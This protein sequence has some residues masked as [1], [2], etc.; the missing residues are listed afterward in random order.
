V[1]GKGCFSSQ[2]NCDTTMGCLGDCDYGYCKIF[3]KKGNV[4]V[5]ICNTKSLDKQ[6]KKINTNQSVNLRI[7][8]FTDPG[9]E[10][11]ELLKLLNWCKVNNIKPILIT[12]MPGNEDVVKEITTC[13][14][15]MHISLGYD[16]LEKS[17]CLHN[18]TND[19]RFM[20]GLS[21]IEKGYNVIFRLVRE[22]TGQADVFTKELISK[23]KKYI[24]LTP[25][26]LKSKPMIQ[27]LGGDISKY[28]FTGGF[29]RPDTL[30]PDYHNLNSCYENKEGI[31]CSKCL[32]K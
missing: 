10:S 17:M 3:Q 22:V 27:Q 13:K 5:K 30:H 6:W 15:I 28:T 29:Y 19:Y 21:Y 8:K 4:E 12:K 31:H 2:Y 1:L 26:R 25:L 23:Y 18:F 24:L 16:D 9:F 32:L 20:V 14:G 7:G 11:K